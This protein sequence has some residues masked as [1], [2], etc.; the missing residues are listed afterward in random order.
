MKISP[1]F[2]FVMYFMEVMLLRYT[3]IENFQV[4]L[5]ASIWPLFYLFTSILF[6]FSV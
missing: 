4:S 5:Q 1:K 6:D 3:F 2:S